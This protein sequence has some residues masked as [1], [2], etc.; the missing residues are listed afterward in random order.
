MSRWFDRTFDLGLPVS[1]A[2]ALIQRLRTVPD[3]LDR[4]VRQLPGVVLTHR[5]EGRWSI[6]ENAGH[7]LDLEALW[8]Q[9]LEDFDRGAPVLHAADLDNR[10]THEARHNDRG[11]DSIV[12]GFRHARER[13]LTRL[14]RMTPAELSRVSLHPRL[15]QKMSVVD[16]AFFVAEH[17]D[18][19]LA[20]IDGLS[21]GLS[22]MPE[23]ALELLNT[24]DPAEQALRMLEE[25]RTKQRPAAGKWS[26][27][28]I[29]GHLVDS[30]SNNHQ[31]FVRAVLQDDLVFTGYAQDDWVA[32]QR[33]QEAPWPELVTLWASFNR[34]LARVMI[35][36]PE[37]ARR[38]PRARHNLHEIGVALPSPGEPARLEDLM[39][40]YVRHLQHHLRQLPG[41]AGTVAPSREEGSGS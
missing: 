28:E 29:L 22:A 26:P 6:Q 21:R 31:R 2:P 9:R 41:S 5:P 24:I 18:H 33:Y 10:K 25:E 37:A 16:L 1:A 23:Y 13:I 17:D 27:R 11:I 4:A 35:A 38:R 20:I 14:D 39:R 8:E 12:A 32:V 34:H 19:H 30:A 7:L 15:Q 36:V 40:D 3:R